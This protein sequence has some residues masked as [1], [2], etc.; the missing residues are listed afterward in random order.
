MGL[1]VPGGDALDVADL[2]FRRI[3][4]TPEENDL[5]RVAY[6]ATG[7]DSLE[8]RHEEFAGET[9]VARYTSWWGVS[10]CSG[11]AG[12]SKYAPDGTVLANK[13]SNELFDLVGRG[14]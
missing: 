9:L 14:A 6:E 7:M 5:R 11:G 3:F 2:H 12:F 10:D 13:G 8:W 4:G 1:R